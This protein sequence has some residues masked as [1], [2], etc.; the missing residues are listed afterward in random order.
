[1]SRKKTMTHSLILILGAIL[2][3]IVFPF[4]SVAAGEVNTS[5]TVEQVFNVQEDV[6]IHE[7]FDYQLIALNNAPMPDSVVSNVYNFS[8]SGNRKISL[9]ISFDRPGIYSYQLT[10]IVKENI[11]G[12]QYD[13]RVIDID[14]YVSPINQNN[15][16]ELT[17]TVKNEEGYKLDQICFTNTYLTEEETQPVDLPDKKNPSHLPKTNDINNSFIKMIGV[18][19]VFCGVMLIFLNNKQR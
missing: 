1:M 7:N 5:I 2:S 18:S 3:F 14:M 10:Q 8:I 15:G 13:Q 12:Y 11:S 9:G 16:L 17:M 6:L 4:K 19:I